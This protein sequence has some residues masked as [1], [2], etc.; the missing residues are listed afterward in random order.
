MVNMSLITH[1]KG[2]KGEH[3]PTRRAKNKRKK[4]AQ[5]TTIAPRI[6]SNANEI[7]ITY[8]TGTGYRVSECLTHKS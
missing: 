4:V 1:P 8:I 5:W 2:Q 7:P 6:M 3:F